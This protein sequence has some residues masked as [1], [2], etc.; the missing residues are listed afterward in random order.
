[1]VLAVVSAATT[2]ACSDLTSYPGQTR[3]TGVSTSV[4]SDRGRF[5]VRSNSVK[6]SETGSKPW[7]GKSSKGQDVW[8][9][10]LLDQNGVVTLEVATSEF[11]SGVGTVGQIDRVQVKSVAPDGSKGVMN[12]NGVPVNAGYVALSLGH[13][14]RNTIAQVQA[15]IDDASGKRTDVVIAQ[16]VVK[17]RPDLRVASIAVSPSV[18]VGVPFDVSATITEIKGDVGARA[19]CVLKADGVAVDR[20]SG[21]WVDAGGSVSCAFRAPEFQSLGTHMLTVVVEHVGPTDYDLANNT[22]SVPVQAVVHHVQLGYDVTVWQ[23]VGHSRSVHA[24]FNNGSNGTSSSSELDV[25]SDHSEQLGSFTAWATLPVRPA[26]GTPIVGGSA[27]TSASVSFSESTNGT[28]IDALQVAAIPI[29]LN[30]GTVDGYG[31]G[32]FWSGRLSD[33]FT[34]SV[35]TGWTAAGAGQTYVQYQRFANRVVYIST[36]YASSYDPANGVAVTHSY[37]LD[38]GTSLGGR[39]FAPYGATATFA[40]YLDGGNF[41]LAANPTL[42]LA[43]A[44][45]NADTRRQCSL[46]SATAGGSE[47]GCDQFFD[48]GVSTTGRVSTGDPN[49]AP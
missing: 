49:A 7:R 26:V 4:S 9:R 31:G 43:S 14:A 42:T 13:M 22:S 3:P 21:M 12:V 6:Y 35:C 16:D 15:N 23:Q 8:S 1:M 40:F 18:I 27:V 28:A 41:T 33:G 37:Y 39:A 25:D 32:C 11:E 20:L 24:I 46:P 2:A 48:S 45:Y 17:F 10:A 38:A 29:H 34:L 47:Y 36:S 30:Y 19:D 44:P 5:T